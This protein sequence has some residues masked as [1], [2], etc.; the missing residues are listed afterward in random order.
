MVTPTRGR[1]ALLTVAEMAAADAAAIRDGITGFALM[2]AAGGAVAEAV[3]ATW[4]RP[5]PVLVLCGPGNNGGDGL[6]AAAALRAAGWPVT[7]ARLGDPARA[8]GDAAAAAARWGGPVRALEP[9][10]GA[11]VAAAG[12]APIVIDALFGAGL[13]RPVDG[14]AAAALAAVTVRD[15]PVVAVDV[16]SG[17]DGDTGQIRGTAPVA[18]RT[19]TFFRRKPG[20]VLLPGRHHAGRVTCVGI[21]IPDRVLDEIGPQTFANGPDLWA[22][23]FPWPAIDTH[24]YRRGHLVVVGGARRPGATRLAARAAQRVGAG[25]VTLAAPPE[26]WAIQ[27]AALASVMVDP[28]ADD[29][30][31]AALLDDPRR[32]ALVLGPGAGVGSETRRRVLAARAAGKAAVLDADALTSFAEAPAALWAA[33]G[34]D[35]VL[36]P[37]DGEFAR[38]F[39]DLADGRD[40]LTRARRAAARAGAV[41]LLKGPDTVIAAP[42]GR[43]AITDNAPPALATAGTGDVLAGMVG[44]LLVQGMPAFEAAAAAAWLHGAAATA[45][46]PGLIA[47]DLE[48]ALVPVL[49]RLGRGL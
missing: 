7:V 27:A 40:R 24:K 1:A 44:G 29:A 4:S 8:S 33:L 43:A 6:I 21:G 35:A 30:A 32:G 19:V 39:P 48:T 16:P 25:L 17:V 45:V 9:D 37:H 10:P 11:V 46:G 5:R 14:A 36:T 18:T 41:V 34:P 47:E 13:A 26:V 42:D 12:A 3:T 31:Y 20:H 49:G 15:W 23:A 28:V 2:A 22:A 38:L